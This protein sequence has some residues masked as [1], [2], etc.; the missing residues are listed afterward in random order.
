MSYSHQ[1]VLWIKKRNTL[2]FLALITAFGLCLRLY[3]LD[4]PCLWYDELCTFVRVNGDMAHTFSTLEVSPFPPLYYILMNV[5]CSIFGFSEFSLRFPS[6]LFSTLSITS[7]Y[8][9]AKSMFSEKEGLIA[10]LLLSVSSYSINYSQEAKM[11]AMMW[12]F[13]ILSF[14]YFFLYTNTQNRKYLIPYSIFGVAAIYTMYLGFLFLL[15]QN[16]L[17]FCLYR[18]K[19][20]TWITVNVLMILCYIPWWHVAIYNMT[21][22]SGITWIKGVGYPEFFQKF[23]KYVSG[24]MIGDS[25]PLEASMQIAL[26]VIAFIFSIY[27]IIKEKQDNH[28]KNYLAV[29]V[30]PA[31]SI[32]IFIAIDKYFTNILI[33][34]YLGFIHIPVVII[35]TVGIT[36]FDHLRLRWAGNLILLCMV[37]SA[38]YFHVLPFHKYGLKINREPWAERVYDLCE[39]ADEKSLVFTNQG[40]KALEYYGK[41]YKGDIV[42]I[43]W[44]QTVEEFIRGNG[45]EEKKYSS[46]FILYRS[47]HIINSDWVRK[48]QVDDSMKAYCGLIQIARNQ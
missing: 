18:E 21:N 32:L 48:H 47:N 31:V 20:K 1:I 16:I 34:R 11:Y 24:I 7:I 5:W 27:L 15:I 17:F 46:I 36:A 22:K 2:I 41:C 33:H 6:M 40:D 10:A 44:W 3:R 35:F 42:V 30:W 4:Y 45:F 39:A 25:V 14:L 38:L 8:F 37:V 19:I 23:F 9:L 43:P 29:F 28:I 26:S 13:C 12:F